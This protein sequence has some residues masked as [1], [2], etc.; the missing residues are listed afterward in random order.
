MQP[1]HSHKPTRMVMV[2]VAEKSPPAQTLAL[3]ASLL[4]TLALSEH[5]PCLLTHRTSNFQAG[6]RQ[7]NSILTTP[8]HS[9]PKAVYEGLSI[10]NLR[11]FVSGFF[12]EY[13]V[14]LDAHE[15]WDMGRTVTGNARAVSRFGKGTWIE[16]LGGYGDGTSLLRRKRGRRGAPWRCAVR[17]A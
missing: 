5:F 9:L 1:A 10:R 3:P 4:T 8:L 14:T 17:L 6:G 15:A 2:L 13:N 16:Q 12:G 11:L 7:C